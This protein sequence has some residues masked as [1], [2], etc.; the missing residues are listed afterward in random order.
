MKETQG[1]MRNWLENEGI[2]PKHAQPSDHHVTTSYAILTT[3]VVTWKQRGRIKGWR[4]LWNL[5]T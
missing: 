5:K 4:Q 1:N 3:L 2:R